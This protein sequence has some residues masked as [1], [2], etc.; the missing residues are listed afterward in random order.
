[1]SL[2]IKHFK[3]ILNL[4][5]PKRVL[6]SPILELFHSYDLSSFPQALSIC[7]KKARNY[8]E[9]SSLLQLITANLQILSPKS[10]EIQLHFKFS[11]LFNTHSQLPFT[12]T[13][14]AAHLLGL[15]HINPSPIRSFQS[16]KSGNL[17]HYITPL[18]KILP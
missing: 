11:Y 7:S 2:S 13:P 14:A 12:W 6:I 1:M 17:K 3:D 15:L 10:S 5:Q 16:S 4:T 9:F 8:A 18:L